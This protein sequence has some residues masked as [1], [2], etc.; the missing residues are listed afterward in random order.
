MEYGNAAWGLR[1]LPLEEQLKLTQAMGL[2]LLELSIANY[3]RDALQPDASAEQ[4][5]QVKALFAQ[6]DVRPDC[7]AT[8]N[9]FTAGSAADVRES[10]DRVKRAADIAAALGVKVLRIFAGFTSDSLV[11]GERFDRALEALQLAAEHV[12]GTGVRLAIE[13]HGGVAATGDVL[14]HSATVTT[15]IDT[16]R[17]L[18]ESLPAAEIGMNYDPANLAAVGD[19]A[20][21]RWFGLFRDRIAL[22][23]LK[24][25]RD[26]PGG[27]VP[28]GCGEGRLDWKALPAVL[29]EYDGPALIE[30]ELP[31]DV[32]DGLRRSL[33]FLKQNQ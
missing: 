22:V 32:E 3:H 11:Y 27:I 16:M 1:E 14:H 30:Y 28:A 23:H 21:E 13:T 31:A 17:K 29:K 7:G 8:G 20:P 2:H 18:L 5:R 26:V 33:R 24:D 15:R 6:Y 4:I 10:L 19:A 25:F 9:D 12:R